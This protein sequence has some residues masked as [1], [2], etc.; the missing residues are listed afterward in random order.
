MCNLYGA[1]NAAPT[2]KHFHGHQPLPDLSG[3]DDE[4]RERAQL[5][6]DATKVGADPVK[7]A[8]L[9]AYAAMHDQPTALLAQLSSEPSAELRRLATTPADVNKAL[10]GPCL[11]FLARALSPVH[12]SGHPKALR[13]IDRERAANFGAPRSS[14]EPRGGKSHSAPPPSLF[15]RV[16]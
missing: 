13:S 15:R 6:S 9:M 3:S 10:Q 2:S 8:R 1:G 7:R 12:A 16:A 11:R 5:R 4:R 14:S